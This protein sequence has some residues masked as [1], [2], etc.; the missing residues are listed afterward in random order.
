M[1]RTAWLMAAAGLCMALAG[2]ALAE[3]RRVEAVGVVPLKAGRGGSVNALDQA[4]QAALLEAVSRVARDFLMEADPGDG[5]EPD[6]EAV[7]GKR[8]VPY[9]TRFRILEDLGERPAMFAD[10]SR[11]SREYVVEVEVFVDAER[12][13]QRLVEAGLLQQ[14]PAM[15]T[16]TRVELELRDL[17]GYGAYQAVRALLTEQ[18]GARRALPR[19]FEKGTAVLDV[20]LAGE[21]ASATSLA[22]RLVGAAT[23]ELAVRPLEVDRGRLVATVEWVP[24]PEAGSERPAQNR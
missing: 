23:P 12:V 15:G 24:A 13:E 1:R 21:G 7:L 2:S 14:D 11:A 8:M 22:K 10:G 19:S 4:I 18:L 17:S 16:F 3:V 20:D 5:E 9:T 6:L